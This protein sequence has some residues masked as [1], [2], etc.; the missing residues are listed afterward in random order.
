M[1]RLSGPDFQNVDNRLMSLKL[2]KNGL[3]NATMFGPDGNVLQ[4]SE[5]LYK[6]NVL[7]LRGRFRPVTK[8]SMDMLIAAKRQFIAEL[9]ITKEEMVLLSEL[10]LTALNPQGNIDEKD[11]LDR[12]DI[13]CSLGQTVMISNFREFYKLASYMSS[14]TRNKKLGIILGLATLDK[15]FENKYY[16]E[17]KGGIL[18]SFGILF[19]NNVKLYVYPT[20]DIATKE[21]HTCSEFHIPE[22]LRGL[23]QYMLDNDKIEDI[24]DVDASVMH[25]ISDNVLQ[26]L[27]T[28]EEG[29]EDC[30]PPQVINMIKIK[31]LFDY[32][33]S[34]EEKQKALEL[35]R[36]RIEKRNQDLQDSEGFAGVRN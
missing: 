17:L 14:Y 4:P 5:A 33:C 35:E 26:M 28:A 27:R 7:V 9:D 25:I 36:Q 32:P 19:G 20:Y 23:F 18:E 3:T 16:S 11:F 13:L 8:V 29:W 6:K 15:I 10:T 31:C 2:V 1:F 12:V 30:V 22:K 21:L 24:K 34:L